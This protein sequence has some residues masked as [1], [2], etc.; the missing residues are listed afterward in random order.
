LTAG[1]RFIKC[2]AKRDNIIYLDPD[3]R[4]DDKITL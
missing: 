3:F 4:R 1:P 2:R